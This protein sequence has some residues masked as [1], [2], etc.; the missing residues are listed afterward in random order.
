LHEDPI[1]PRLPIVLLL[2]NAL[3]LLGHSL[4]CLLLLLH[5]LHETVEVTLQDFLLFVNEFLLGRWLRGCVLLVVV[6]GGSGRAR[7]LLARPRWSGT[8]SSCTSS[9]RICPTC[10]KSKLEF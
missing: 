10:T 3:L 2:D 8:N 9:T 5:H 6:R 4:H 7:G 1:L